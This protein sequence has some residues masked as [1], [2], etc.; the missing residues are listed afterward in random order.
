MPLKIQCPG[1]RIIATVPDSAAGKSAKCGCGQIIAIP[2]IIS[3]A[4]PILASADELSLQPVA[5]APHHNSTVASTI[6]PES[7][8]QVAPIPETRPDHSALRRRSRRELN[9]EE[10]QGDSE[11]ERKAVRT[12][13]F[14]GLL[15]TGL[16]IL[17]MY[18]LWS[19]PG[20]TSTVL[21]V[22]FMLIGAGIAAIIAAKPMI[23][24]M[25]PFV[26][27]ILGSSS[28]SATPKPQQSAAQRMALGCFVLIGSFALLLIMIPSKPRTSPDVPTSSEAY[29][30]TKNL[31]RKRLKSPSSA[32]FPWSATRTWD[33]KN[34]KFK[35]LAYVDAQNSF[36]ANLRKEFTCII[37][38]NT[39]G[40]DGKPAE[41]N[42]TDN[43]K[44]EELHIDGEDE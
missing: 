38:F 7:Q 43:W 36:G 24:R 20:T 8:E 16:C 17:M 37:E 42:D 21:V 3:D 44:V 4:P 26:V 32:S 9:A 22:L 2:I 41:W 29:T 28:G 25:P 18:L 33:L 1:C 19:L 39:T 40:R 30:I 11:L 10:E 14:A 6:P 34:G 13:R 35:I 27:R 15:I 23:M 5:P 31:V 12:I